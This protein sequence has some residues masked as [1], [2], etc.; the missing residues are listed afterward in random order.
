MRISGINWRWKVDDWPSRR[1]AARLEAASLLLHLLTIVL[2]CVLFVAKAWAGSLLITLLPALTTRTASPINFTARF[3]SFAAEPTKPFTPALLR[4]TSNIWAGKWQQLFLQKISFV[5]K[6]NFFQF[7]A[8]RANKIFWFSDISR[9]SFVRF[10]T[11]CIW[12]WRYCHSWLQN[13]F[14]EKEKKAFP[15]NPGWKHR[16]SSSNDEIYFFC[17]HQR[18]T[19][20]NSEN[21]AKSLPSSHTCLKI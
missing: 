8:E 9:E 12:N 16:D 1:L 10:Q 13:V 7:Q 3:L 4:P 6:S 15:E 19:F 2:P 14:F 11:F 5:W 18:A 21:W 20:A 17:N